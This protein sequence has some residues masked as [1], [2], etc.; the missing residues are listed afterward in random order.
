MHFKRHHIN[1][2]VGNEGDCKDVTWEECK[3]VNKTVP[4]PEP[5]MMCEPMSVPYN[6]VDVM[7][8]EVE[9]V[10]TD[11]VAKPQQVC[12]P[13]KTNK[14]GMAMY[15]RITEVP[16]KVCK[17]ITILVPAQDEIHKQWCLFNEVKN[18]DFNVAVKNILD[19]Q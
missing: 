16:E 13:V 6:D 2:I 4:F 19:N 15:T 12:K 1:Y 8:G 3:K 14:C 10:Q 11:C 17:D 18:I 7:F 5:Q 9:L